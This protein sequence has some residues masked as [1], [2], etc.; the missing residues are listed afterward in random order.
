MTTVGAPTT[1]QVGATRAFTRTALGVHR[2]QAANINQ[3]RALRD[4]RAQ[5]VAR[6][7]TRLL[8]ARQC[9]PHAPLG[10]GSLIGVS[11]KYN[12]RT[13]RLLCSSLET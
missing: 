5:V 13:P 12:I 2:V 6:D 1:A 7:I 11:R 10:P 4:R 8:L 9:V 3:R